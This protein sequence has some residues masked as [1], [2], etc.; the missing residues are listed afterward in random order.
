MGAMQNNLKIPGGNNSKRGKTKNLDRLKA[1]TKG[2]AGGAATWRMADP[3]L[4]HAVIVA[5]ADMG[6]AVLFGHSMDGG[7]Y[8]MSLYLNK[9]KT[10]I[11]FN[12]DAELDE[13]LQV[14]IDELNAT[15]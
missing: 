15:D 4:V 12:G 3:K 10:T 9:D 13:E 6:G 8:S 11:W 5:I 7:S 14:V 1:L 2:P